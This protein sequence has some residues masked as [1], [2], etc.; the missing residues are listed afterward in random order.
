MRQWGR[1]WRLIYDL[2][3]RHGAENMA[4][5]E[6]IMESVSSGAQPPTLRLYGWH[7]PCV[8]LGYGQR[9]SA[10]DQERLAQ[11]GWDLVR[12]PTGGRAI[13][14]VD[15]LTYSLSFPAD[16][17]L[18]AG[19]VLESYRRISEG[20]M[21]GMR[22]LALDTAFSDADMHEKS[23]SPVCFDQPGRFEITFGGR[24]LI[25][26]AQLRRQQAVLQHGTLPLTGDI[27]RLC[28]VLRYP[29]EDARSQDILHVRQQ[30]LTLADAA[31]R[32]VQWRE[33]ADALAEGMAYAL[34]AD[35][36]AEPLSAAEL[37][38]AHQIETER[39]ADD[40]WT[41]RR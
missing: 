24:K 13:L 34:H 40:G 28:Q 26:S 32:E 16:H 21:D 12:R 39:Y 31:E 7:P 11:F 10:V 14:H 9:A 27:A 3:T 5:D 19:G 33:A 6:A 38:R 8:S 37:E 22:R 4:I 30:A 18:A 17:P 29:D 20:L 23:I 36:H 41:F 35:M 2:P 15:E 25:G 1:A